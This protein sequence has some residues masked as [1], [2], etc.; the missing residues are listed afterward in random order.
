MST[1]NIQLRND[2]VINYELSYALNTK[3]EFKSIEFFG[4][5]G[6]LKWPEGKISMLK[7]NRIIK[8]KIKIEKHLASEK[9]VNLFIKKIDKKF[10][11]SYLKQIKFSVELIEK[12]YKFSKNEKN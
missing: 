10:S 8:K 1:G 9:Q 7:K 5:K 4:T 12:L 3:D 2:C 6:S 11:L